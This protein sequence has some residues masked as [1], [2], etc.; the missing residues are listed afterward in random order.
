MTRTQGRTQ[1]T[2]RYSPRASCFYKLSTET[3][4]AGLVLQPQ[5]KTTTTTTTP[6]VVVGGGHIVV[7]CGADKDHNWF[8]QQCSGNFISM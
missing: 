7:C 5:T 4:L 6:L 2:T 3:E 8:Q 1:Y